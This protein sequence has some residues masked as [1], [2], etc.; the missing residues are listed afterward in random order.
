MVGLIAMHCTAL[1]CTALHPLPAA[2]TSDGYFEGEVGGHVP[3]RAPA[4]VLVA[5]YSQQGHAHVHEEHD[6]RQLCRA[7]GVRASRCIYI[8]VSMSMCTVHV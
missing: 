8:Y 3:P 4:Q 1:H 6:H 5:P 2:L 7:V